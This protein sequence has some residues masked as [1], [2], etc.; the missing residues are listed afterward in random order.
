MRIVQRSRHVFLLKRIDGIGAACLAGLQAA[1]AE[2][3]QRGRKQLQKCVARDIRRAHPFFK[4]VQKPRREECLA[5]ELA[6]RLRKRSV[7]A[8]GRS[9]LR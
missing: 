2:H 9:G 4:P 6:G 8:C 7:R 1:F 5:L 3:L